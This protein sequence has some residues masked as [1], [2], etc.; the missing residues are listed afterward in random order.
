MFTV[1]GQEMLLK[2]CEMGFD[3]QSH[4][5]HAPSNGIYGN[6]AIVFRATKV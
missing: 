1:F 4:Y 5:L 3:V 6:G 2:L